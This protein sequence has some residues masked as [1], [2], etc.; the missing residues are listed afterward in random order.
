MAMYRLDVDG[1]SAAAIRTIDMELVERQMQKY[2]KPTERDFVAHI[3][4]MRRAEDYIVLYR[5]L[6]S[7]PS[8]PKTIDTDTPESIAFI[9]MYSEDLPGIKL[10]KEVKER[11]RTDYTGIRNMHKF[12]FHLHGFEYIDNITVNINKKECEVF[13]S[14]LNI[15]QLWPFRS[16]IKRG[17]NM[18]VFNIGQVERLFDDPFLEVIVISTGEIPVLTVTY[19]CVMT[20]P[21]IRDAL[22]NLAGKTEVNC[23][24]DTWELV[25][26]NGPDRHKCDTVK[27]IDL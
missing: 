3:L 26:L 21:S 18:Y 6:Q 2:G 8:F 10:C 20:S 5:M 14:N 25:T 11:D 1:G 9:P 19:N 17:N 13:M 15:K 4:T 24:D 27:M 23:Y 22:I 7:L 12:R 16:T